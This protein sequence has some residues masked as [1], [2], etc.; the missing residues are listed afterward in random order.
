MDGVTTGAVSRADV[1]A[2][3]VAALE[4]RLNLRE[5]VLLTNQ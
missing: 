3:I 5:A 4:G 1:A 2:Y